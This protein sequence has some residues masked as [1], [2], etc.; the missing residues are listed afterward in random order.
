MYAPER[1]QE[2]LRLARDSGRVDVVSL[3]RRSRCPRDHPRDLRRW[4]DRAGLVRRVHGAGAIRTG[5]LDFEPDSPSGRPP[6]ATRRTAS[7]RPPVAETPVWRHADR[8]RRFD[9]RAAGRIPAAE[10]LT[11]VTHSLPIAARSPTTPAIQLHLVGGRVRHPY[12]RRRGR[13]GAARVRRIR[14]DV[15]FVA[16]NGFFSPNT[17]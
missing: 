15:M 16:A 6:R 9:A 12:A 7:P 2:I 17:G 5:R 10:L 1:Q 8:R 4:L 11:V 3:A 14:A 13:L